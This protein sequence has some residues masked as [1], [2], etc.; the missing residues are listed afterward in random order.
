MLI[1][2]CISK[3][4]ARFTFILGDTAH[5]FMGGGKRSLGFVKREIWFVFIP[6]PI[7]PV[8]PFFFFSRKSPSTPVL[9][10]ELVMC[11]SVRLRATLIDHLSCQYPN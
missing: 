11:V 10:G 6:M 7:I 8:A 5:H 4:K 9:F 3:A 2:T 1:Y